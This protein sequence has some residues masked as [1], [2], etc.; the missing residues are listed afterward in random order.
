MATLT[1]GQALEL[2]DALGIPCTQLVWKGRKAPPPPYVVLAPHESRHAYKDGR[3][4]GKARRYDF[5]LYVRERDLPLEQ[6][7]ESALDGA[8]VPYTSD[9]VIDEENKYVV[10]Y[11]STT[12]TEQEAT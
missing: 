5:E 3:V 11:F 9:A 10:T 2:I 1:V 7:I 4:Y 8:G 12:L 6:R